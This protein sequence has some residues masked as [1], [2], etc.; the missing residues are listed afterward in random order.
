MELEKD[1]ENTKMSSLYAA[2][3]NYHGRIENLILSQEEQQE[4]KKTGLLNS[5]FSVS[6]TMVWNRKH[7]GKISERTSSLPTLPEKHEKY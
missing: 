4:I 6:R 2:I 5:W 1:L 7:E 3:D